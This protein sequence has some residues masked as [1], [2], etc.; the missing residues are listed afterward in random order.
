MKG[1]YKLQIDCGRLGYLRGLFI[2]KVE[3]INK[4]IND[5]I[6]IY[7]GEVLGKFSQISEVITNENVILVTTDV[8]IIDIIIKYDLETGYN[9]LDYYEN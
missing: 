8:N 5:K 4:L 1:L 3:E 2:A 7:F 9:P 6:E